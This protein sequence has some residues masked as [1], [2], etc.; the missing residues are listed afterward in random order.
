MQLTCMAGLLGAP[1]LSLPLS[2]VQGL[3]VGL[4]LVVVAAATWRYSNWPVATRFF[5]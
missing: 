5:N 4:C 2:T 1:A 3:P